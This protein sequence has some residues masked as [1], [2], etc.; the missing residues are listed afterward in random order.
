MS[1]PTTPI[2]GAVNPAPSGTYRIDAERSF[3]GFR[4]KAFGLLWVSGRMP[5]VDG[6]VRIADGVLSG[7]GTVAASGVDTGLG[8]RDWHLRSSHYLHAA[9]HPDITLA[10]D[11]AV[12]ETG[13]A[14]CT[15]TVRGT[16]APMRLRL[17]AL[18][19]IDGALHLRANAD[20]DRTPFP[21]LPPL[22]GVS[23]RVQ[24]ELNVV[25]ERESS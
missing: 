9:T 22:A 3:L 4:A 5:A 8:A 7:G 14:D 2:S 23:R 11:N 12:I 6:S 20:L 19:V 24:L 1:E 17:T 15:V 25:A 18:D 13:L 21:M 16:A 10:V